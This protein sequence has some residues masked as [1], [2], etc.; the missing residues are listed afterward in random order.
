MN[1]ST[2]HWLDI[3]IYSVIAAGALWGLW[4]GFLRQM[5]RL[6]LLILSFY[7]AL[8]CHEWAGRTF[9]TLL[10]DVVPSARRPLAF[11]VMFLAFYLALWIAL[12]LLRISARNLMPKERPELGLGWLNRLLGAGVGAMLACVFVGGAVLALDRVEEARFQA[13]L[14]G[15]RCRAT[16]VNATETVLARIPHRYRLDFLAALE[17]ARQDGLDALGELGARGTREATGILRPLEVK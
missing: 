17:Q 7:G 6:T 16:F 9:G 2:L 11:G 14:Q 8:G 13:E 3:T 4:T 12:C 1:A 5:T 15:S 10:K